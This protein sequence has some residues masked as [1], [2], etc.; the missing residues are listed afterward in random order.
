MN[1]RN[2]DQM[3]LIF[4][5]RIHSSKT[6]S[7]ISL[8][9]A[10][11][12]TGFWVECYRVFIEGGKSECLVRK[13]LWARREPTKKLNPHVSDSEIKPT[14]HWCR[15]ASSLT[16]APYL[17]SSFQFTTTS[18]K[19]KW[20]RE[21]LFFFFYSSETRERAWNRLPRA[22][23][24]FPSLDARQISRT[25]ACWLKCPV[26]S[27]CLDLSVPSPLPYPR[28]ENVYRVIK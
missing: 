19:A 1:Y 15:E 18:S 8:L 26:S 13:P 4:H 23:R 22:N 12:F 28:C 7:N 21:K 14:T 17:F 24:S 16:T 27:A 20:N 10:N 11:I 25:L 9:P 3:N 2:D 6:H 5:L